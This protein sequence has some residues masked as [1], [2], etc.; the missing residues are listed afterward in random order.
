M[1]YGKNKSEPAEVLGAD[2]ATLQ[3]AADQATLIRRV[4]RYAVNRLGAE[5]AALLFEPKPGSGGLPKVRA[6]FGFEGEIWTDGVSRALMKKLMREGRTTLVMDSRQDPS[7]TLE[8]GPRSLLAV[9]LMHPSGK[10]AGLLYADHSQPGAFDYS[11]RDRAAAAAALFEQRV[12]DLPSGESSAPPST[13]KPR[14][15]ASKKPLAA[16]VIVLL[17]LGLGLAS[18]LR[19]GTK[20]VAPPAPQAA[21]SQENLVIITG[22]LMQEQPSKIKMLLWFPEL[23]KEI[24]LKAADIEFDPKVGRYRAEVVLPKDQ[25]PTEFGINIRSKEL[26]AVRL[27]GL[28]LRETDE[29]LMGLVPR[30]RMKLPKQ[31]QTLEPGRTHR[32]KKQKSK[33]R[34]MDAS[35]QAFAEHLK[36]LEAKYRGKRGP[37]DG[38]RE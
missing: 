14:P 32:V 22:E 11:A 3:S 30:V 4:T 28:T 16:V 7:F 29:G 27:R 12:Y 26:K 33:P 8:Q 1:S 6:F 37:K 19:G 20:P 13:P 18:R 24:R 5:R 25:Q 9:P 17:V 34:Q 21:R 15:S 23:E 2:A 38:G 36:R 35:H 31:G 10:V